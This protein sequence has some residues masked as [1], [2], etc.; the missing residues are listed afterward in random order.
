[1]RKVIFAVAMLV[2]A[3]PASASWRLIP[4]KPYDGHIG[5]NRMYKEPCW[6]AASAKCS[7]E[8][9]RGRWMPNGDPKL[10]TRND[11]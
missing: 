6:S 2:M 11:R 4:G 9:A 7:L 10:N 3:Q 8:R 1:M 5:F